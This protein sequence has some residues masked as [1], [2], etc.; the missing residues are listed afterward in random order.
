M[1]GLC[2]VFALAQANSEPTPR[3][4][5][6]DVEFLDFLG[7][8]RT[9]A[10]HWVDPFTMAED[11]PPDSRQESIT[12]TSRPD[13]GAR[14]PSRDSQPNDNQGTPRDLIWKQTGP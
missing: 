6:V 1:L 10:G 7:S 14:T 5:E 2:L 8:W 4:E 11:L 12:D 3:P 13:A 9:E